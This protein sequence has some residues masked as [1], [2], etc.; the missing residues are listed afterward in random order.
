MQINRPARPL[1]VALLAALIAV[2]ACASSG[3]APPAG[4]GA[5]NSRAAATSLAAPTVGSAEDAAAL[6]VASDPRFEGVIPRNPDIIGA[7]RGGEASA[8]DD[9]SYPVKV[10]I[11]WGD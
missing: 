2:A 4:T 9:G 6:V 10:T 1:L 7:S 3:A 8:N 11:G 5:P